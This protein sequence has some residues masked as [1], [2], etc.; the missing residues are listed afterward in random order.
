MHVNTDVI[1]P[2]F[3]AQWGNVAAAPKMYKKGIQIPK[4]F[5]VNDMKT[6]KTQAAA[7]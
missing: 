6:P 5:K 4:M 3:A 7:F 2:L 1:F